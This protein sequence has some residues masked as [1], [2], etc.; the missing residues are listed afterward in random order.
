MALPKTLVYAIRTAT[1]CRQPNCLPRERQHPLLSKPV[2]FRVSISQAKL[3]TFS[4][5]TPFPNDFLLQS[6]ILNPVESYV[7]SAGACSRFSF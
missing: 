3:N 2:A 1:A 5:G 6:A 4:T 7:W